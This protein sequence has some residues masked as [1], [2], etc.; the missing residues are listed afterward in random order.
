MTFSEHDPIAIRVKLRL[1][2]DLTS[3]GAQNALMGSQMFLSDVQTLR[4]IFLLEQGNVAEALKQFDLATSRDVP[5]VDRRI[6]ER[7]SEL[8]R[9][10]AP[11]K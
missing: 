11:P 10:Y 1:E 6:A 5:F 4:G 9:K 8:L 2:L 7:Y 3:L